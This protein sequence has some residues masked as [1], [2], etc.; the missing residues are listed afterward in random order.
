[1]LVVILILAG[2]F[3]GSILSI[4]GWVTKDE[5]EVSQL[6]PHEISI[7]E[8]IKNGPG[9]NRHVTLTDFE[10]G[11]WVVQTENNSWKEVTIAMF[12]AGGPDDNIEVVLSS[13]SINSDPMLRQFLAQKKITGICSKA[14]RSNWGATLGPE[15]VK[16]ND[17]AP[18]ASPWAVHELR[19]PPTEGFVNGVFNA[20]YISFG[21]VIA[22]ALVVFGKDLIASF[23][24]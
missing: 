21:L 13:R 15:L 18:L 4:M 16:A 5:F 20:A 3:A 12:P 9:E 17:G 8:L 23:R 11:G 14:R 2:L 19:N 24:R 22:I 1:V 6:P 10:P 7:A